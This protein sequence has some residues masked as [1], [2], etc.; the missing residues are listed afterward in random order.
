MSTKLSMSISFK[1]ST[2]KTN[3]NHNNRT[4]TDKQKE[5]NNHINYD[6]SDRN[7]YLVQED[8]K[9]LYEKEFGTALENYNQKQKRTDRKIDNYYEHVK[10]SKK[11]ALQQEMIIQVGDRE[12]FQNGGD[13]R[14]GNHVLQEWF[15]DFEKRN[16]NLKVYNASIHNDEASPHLHFN[17]VPVASGY[18]R[19]LEK[20]VSFDKAIIQQDHTL[21]KVRPFA[22]WREK[23]IDL[24]AKELEKLGVERKLV[25]TNGYKDVNDYKEKKDLERDIKQL[26]KDLSMKKQELSAYSKDRKVKT[27]LDEIS[28]TKQMREIEVPSEER[29]IFGRTKM[30]TVKQSTGYRRISEED[31]EKLQ[32]FYN[33]SNQRDTLLFN[34]L[35]TDVLKEN[36]QLQEEIKQISSTVKKQKKE[37]GNLYVENLDLSGEIEDLKKDNSILK[38]HRDDLRDEI[39]LVYKCTKEFLKE[40]TE[41]VNAFKSAFKVLVDKITRKLDHA[42]L[43]NSFKKEYE[44]ENI[45]KRSPGISR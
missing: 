9:E 3:I 42:E 35:D 14:I 33:F 30:K 32:D 2:N 6:R 7:V 37:N 28:F 11:T 1:K 16:P 12:Y 34:L 38:S 22:D 13:W 40:N 4:M 5:K 29:N 23:E 26:E 19:G 17:F 27:K 39:S 31:F 24:I 10:D 20:Q 15:K 41:N 25:G 44:K 21:D 8:L 36:K 43:N 45:I 18:K